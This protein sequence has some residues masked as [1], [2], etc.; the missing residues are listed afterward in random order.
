MISISGRGSRRWRNHDRSV[1]TVRSNVAM[2]AGAVI[3]FRH[4]AKKPGKT[5]LPRERQ[6]GIVHSAGPLCPLAPALSH[7]LSV[8]ALHSAGG[9]SGEGAPTV[10]VWLLQQLAWRRRRMGYR[11]NDAAVCVI[12]EDLSL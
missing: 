7:L 5:D 11:S 10:L 6:T 9:A 4:P 3:A 1:S 2:A 12:S 8:T